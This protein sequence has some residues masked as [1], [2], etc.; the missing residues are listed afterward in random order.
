MPITIIMGDCNYL[1]R[2]N[3]AYGHEYGDLLLKR[4]G[5]VIREICRLRAWP[6]GWAAMNS[7]LPAATSLQK[8]PNS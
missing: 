2:V 4:V 7:S 1:K 5:R 6:C 3:D 8:R